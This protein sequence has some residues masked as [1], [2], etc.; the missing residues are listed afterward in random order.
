VQEI[1]HFFWINGASNYI[2]QVNNI[3]DHKIKIKDISLYKNDN[4]EKLN[5]LFKTNGSDKM[6]LGYH[7]FYGHIINEE[8][9]INLLEI[10]LGTLDPSFASTMAFYKEEV[11]S[12]RESNSDC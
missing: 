7:K 1:I 3:L 8:S 10:G 12:V 5:E 6:L 9:K 4:I 2:S 11:G